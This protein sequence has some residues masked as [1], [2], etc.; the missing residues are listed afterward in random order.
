MGHGRKLYSYMYENFS[1]NPQVFDITVEDPNDIFQ[2]VRDK[3]DVS[4]LLEAGALEGVLP[5]QM[6]QAHIKGLQEKFR[7]CEVWS[8]CVSISYVAHLTLFFL[9]FLAPSD[10]L[11][12]THLA[13]EN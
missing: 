12:R 11:C 7:L 6:T 8:L 3:C 9:V 2:E 4:L 13:Q 1:S 5:S 10:S